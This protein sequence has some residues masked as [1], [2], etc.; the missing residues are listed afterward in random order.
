MHYAGQVLNLHGRAYFDG[1]TSTVP[2]DQLGIARWR[3]G[4]LALRDREVIYYLVDP[5]E[6]ARALSGAHEPQHWAV[7]VDGEGNM[8]RHRICAI[9]QEGERRS[10]YGPRYHRRLRLRSEDGEVDI[11]VRYRAPAEN[12]PFYLRFLTVG[13]CHRSGEQA[14]GTAELLLPDKVDLAWQRPFVR[15]RHHAIG[16]RNSIWLPLFNGP[17]RTRIR[18]LMRGVASRLLPGRALPPAASVSGQ[19]GAAS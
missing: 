1:N 5:C 4:R 2:L 13:Q 18:R 14:A 6:P 11:S 17:R 8:S 12:G 16:G 3:W 9:E 10:L 15:M 7:V 19:M